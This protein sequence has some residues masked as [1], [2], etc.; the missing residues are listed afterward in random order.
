[1]DYQKEVEE[2]ATNLI[3]SHSNVGGLTY[4]EAL[5]IAV[6]IQRNKIISRVGAEV[7]AKNIE[8]V[9]DEEIKAMGMWRESQFKGVTTDEIEVMDKKMRES[10]N[11]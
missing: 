10:Y 5:Q 1:M 11:D 4:F 7:V 8:A 3:V 2:I 9:T 6:H